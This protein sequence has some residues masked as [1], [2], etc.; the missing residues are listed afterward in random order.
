D[1]KVILYAD[2]MTRSLKA[3]IA[4]TER[5][6]KIQSEYNE[7]HGITPASIKKAISDVMHS[8]YEQDHYTVSIPADHIPVGSNMA[9]HIEMLRT[10]MLA[11]AADLEFEEAARLR[12]EI[13]KLEGTAQSDASTK[14]RRK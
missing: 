13:A 3:A 6:R 4:E 5:R 10:R 14:K 1:S 12:D 8:V 2:T 9:A 11:A 7:K